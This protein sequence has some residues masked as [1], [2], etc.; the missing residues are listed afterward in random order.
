MTARLVF[1]FL[2]VVALFQVERVTYFCSFWLRDF[3]PHQLSYH[4]HSDKLFL[5]FV[6]KQDPLIRFFNHSLKGLK[7]SKVLVSFYSNTAVLEL[8]LRGQSMLKNT[9]KKSCIFN[10]VTVNRFLLKKEKENKISSLFD[11]LNN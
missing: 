7:M 11:F 4:Y 6:R 2:I 9:L 8:H 3:C 5:P 1:L 10:R